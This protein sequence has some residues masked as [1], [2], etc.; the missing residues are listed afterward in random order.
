M[1]LK[2]SMFTALLPLLLIGLILAACGNT[3]TGNGGTTPTAAPTATA[4][5]APAVVKTAS[6]T[7]NGATKT[8]LTDANGMTLYTYKPDTAT[9]SACTG[10]CLTN[11]PPLKFSGSSTPTASSTLPGSL[12]AVA[13]Q[14][15]YQGHFLY[16]F[17]GDTAA[18][19]TNGEGKGGV[20]FVATTDLST[21]S[22]SGNGY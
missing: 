21:L 15:Q 13:G 7:V 9:T 16:T 10:Q 6:A 2:R 19:Q 14:V 5:A 4:T 17:A 11:W 1:F 22:S 20:W 3:T 18:G 12:T 8:I